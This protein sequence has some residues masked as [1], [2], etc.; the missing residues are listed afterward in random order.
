MVIEPHIADCKT[1]QVS[2]TWRGQRTTIRSVLPADLHAIQSWDEDPEIISLMG[3]KFEA[4][5]AAEW[6]S[7]VRTGINC[8]ALAIEDLAG[9]LIGEVEFAQVDRRSGDGE[10]RLC[11]GAKECWGQG[12]G[13]DALA[14]A[15]RFAYTELGLTRVY[16]RVY[17]SNVRAVRLYRRLGFLTEGVLEPSRRRNDPSRILLMNL[18]RKRWAAVECQRDWPAAAAR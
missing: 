11:I 17:E 3:R 7:E 14:L 15:L 9:R 13:G 1:D 10:V 16:L 8:T 4:I 6:F 2:E 18:T 12:Y 5:S